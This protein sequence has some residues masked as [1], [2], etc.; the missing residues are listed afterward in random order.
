MIIR[1]IFSDKFKQALFF[2]TI[3][4][5]FFQ[6]KTNTDNNTNYLSHLIATDNVNGN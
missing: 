6:V 1:I 3:N 5:F 4:G 2:K